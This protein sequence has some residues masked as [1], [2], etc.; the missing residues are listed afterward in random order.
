MASKRRNPNNLDVIQDIKKRGVTYCKRKKN[1]IRKLIEISKLC[2]LNM[3]LVI[4]DKEK[5]TMLE[6]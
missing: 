3:F 4:F 6:Y 5:Q 1:L 2:D